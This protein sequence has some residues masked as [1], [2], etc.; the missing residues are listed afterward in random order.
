[1]GLEHQVS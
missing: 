1:L